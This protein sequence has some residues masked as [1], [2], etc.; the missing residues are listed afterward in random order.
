MGNALLVDDRFQRCN[1]DSSEK[2][3]ETVMRPSRARHPEDFA[4]VPSERKRRAHS[5]DS[6]ALS[7]T[8]VLTPI[9]SRI[10]WRRAMQTV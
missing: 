10:S 3:T 1:T 6:H 7:V 5:Q 4:P 8:K 2:R 9:A